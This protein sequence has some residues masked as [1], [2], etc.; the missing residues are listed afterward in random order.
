MSV[1]SLSCLG[2]RAFCIANAVRKWK[3][4]ASIGFNLYLS[5]RF[6]DLAM[7]YKRIKVGYARVSTEE[8]HL[9][10]QLT[11]LKEHGCSA[12]FFDKGISGARFDR[13]GLRQAFEAVAGGGTLVVWRLD[14]LGRSLQH[15]ASIV[16]DL[17]QQRVRL[18]SLSE[19]IDT[20][21]TTGRF[22][23]HMLAALAE[24]ERG[25][26]SERTRAGMEAARQRGSSIGRPSG[27]S[28]TQREQARVLLENHS[29]D[30]VAEAFN[31]HQRTLKRHLRK[32]D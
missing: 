2:S 24:F 28:A 20:G 12:V 27:M 14:R 25:L 30:V 32:P 18:L 5:L 11:A 6:I 21:S 10:M 19:Y 1:G 4:G 31:V 17:E 15:L 3:K 13:P 9:D 23:F 16:V 22:T 29:P 26:I 8:Q 7:P